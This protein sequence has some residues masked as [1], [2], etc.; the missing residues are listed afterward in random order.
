MQNYWT[1]KADLDF[2][3]G[4]FKIVLLEKLS[5]F[6]FEKRYMQWLIEYAATVEDERC[7][8]TIWAITYEYSVHIQEK[9][10]F[11]TFKQLESSAQE[12]GTKRHEGKRPKLLD[13][14]PEM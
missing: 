1:L 6:T 11:S 7:E 10:Y 8:I 3:E 5:L 13:L 4:S 12:S 2:I 14:K 9:W